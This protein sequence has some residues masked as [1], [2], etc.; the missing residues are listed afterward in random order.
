[1]AVKI[2]NFQVSLF[3]SYLKDSAGTAI[4]RDINF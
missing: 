2:R 3:F 1:M 4:K